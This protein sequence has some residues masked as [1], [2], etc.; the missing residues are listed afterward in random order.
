M[1]EREWFTSYPKAVLTLKISF[2]L[3]KMVKIYFDLDL[4]NKV[5]EEA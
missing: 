4:K 2:I 3:V 1:H 5:K